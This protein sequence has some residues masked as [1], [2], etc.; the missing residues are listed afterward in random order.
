MLKLSNNTNPNWFAKTEVLLVASSIGS[1]V[2]AIIF[3]QVAFAAITSIPLSLAISLN[4]S[5]RKR[6]ESVDQQH[7][8]SIIQL[9]QNSNKQQSINQLFYSLPTRAELADIESRLEVYKSAFAEQLYTLTKEQTNTDLEL[10]QINNYHD[11]ADVQQRLY[12]LEN[13]LQLHNPA[14]LRTELQEN[15]VSTEAKIRKLEQQFNNLPISNLQHQLLQLQEHVNKLQLNSTESTQLYQ[16]LLGEIE[17]LSQQVQSVNSKTQELSLAQT[18]IQNQLNSLS[19]PNLDKIDDEIKFLYAF[20]D[21]EFQA[22]V[23]RVEGKIIDTTE[24]KQHLVKEVQSISQQV[25][26][27]SSSVSERITKIQVE[28]QSHQISVEKSESKMYADIYEL[29]DWYRKLEEKIEILSKSSSLHPSSKI[30]KR[31]IRVSSLKE[32]QPICETC[33]QPCQ[34]KPIEGGFLFNNKFG[35]RSCKTHFEKRNGLLY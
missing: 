23:A 4:S 15:L 28:L 6:L 2:A 22:L 35:C 24:L 34:S 12:V 21:R 14:H 16:C 31:E 7:K 10:Q 5:N 20:V 8:A 27:V 13:F 18:E 25:Q 29:T 32:I 30:E 3:Q 26:A 33:N 1:S 9:E 19:A 17:F 11:I